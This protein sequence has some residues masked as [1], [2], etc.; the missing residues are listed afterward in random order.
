MPASNKD[1]ADRFCPCGSNVKYVDCCF[2][3][4]DKRSYPQT[5]EQLMR[6][7]YS[8]YVL[9]LKSYLLETWAISTR[10][11]QLEFENGLSWQ[12]LTINS[13]KKGRLKDQQGWVTFTACYQIGFDQ[14]SF[15][16][17]SYFNRDSNGQWCYVDGLFID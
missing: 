9:H 11:G 13:L 6:S 2:G 10:P 16:E 12:S 17:K 1:C 14:L 15:Q 4:H 7:R 8:A 5:A 3:F